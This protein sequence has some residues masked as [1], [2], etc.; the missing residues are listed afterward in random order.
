MDMKKHSQE[1]G[2]EEATPKNSY[3]RELK[4]LGGVTGLNLGDLCV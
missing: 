1:L 4:T 3:R 2:V